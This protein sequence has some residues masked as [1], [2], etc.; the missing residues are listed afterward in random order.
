MN[1]ELSR[2]DFSDFWGAFWSPGELLAAG[3]LEGLPG[4]ARLAGQGDPRIQSTCPE[5]GNGAD[6]GAY[7]QLSNSQPSYPQP[8]NCIPSYHQYVYLCI[9]SDC[10]SDIQTTIPS[11]MPRSL[12]APQGGRRITF[13]P[14]GLRKVAAATRS[15]EPA[16]IQTYF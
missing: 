12:V 4:L 5:G 9:H 14:S 15:R 7:C 8:S 11:V 10:T 16:K 13:L 3:W 6:P 2:L 1:F